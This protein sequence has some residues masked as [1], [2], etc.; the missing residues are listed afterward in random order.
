MDL[1]SK[2]LRT[3]LVSH[4]AAAGIFL[5][6]PAKAQTPFFSPSA[7][8][9]SPSPANPPRVPNADPALEAA[10]R[11]FESL[12]EPDRIAIQDGLIWTGDYKGIADGKFGKGTRDAIAAFASRNKLPTDGT[13]DTKGRASL[14][15]MAQ[16]AKDAVRFMV[17]TDAK[18]GLRIGLPLKLLPK[19]KPLPAGTRLSSADETFSVETTTSASALPDAYAAMIADAAG[20]KVTYKVLRPDFF[21]VTGEIGTNAF[22]TRMA[23]GRRAGA[24]AL[25]GFTV[26]YPIAAKSRFDAITIAI[27][28]SFTPFP[29]AAAV[30]TAPAA[31]QGA[32]AIPR[33]IAPTTDNAGS[34]P[35]LTASGI[36][37][38]PGFVLTSLPKTCAEPSIRAKKAKIAKQSETDGLTLLSLPEAGTEVLPLRASDPASPA[39]IVVLSFAPKGEG[40]EL[41]GASGDLHR[42]EAAAAWR[43]LAPVQT[44]VAGAAVLDRSGALA[45]L[46]PADANPVKLIAGILPQMSRT[47]VPASKLAAFL[48]ETKPKTASSQESHTTGMIV[49]LGRAAMVPIYCGR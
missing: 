10:K 23:R 47:I 12:Q 25:N 28:N 38:A 34:K 26:T 48:A 29:D 19:T 24:E 1:H 42:P 14:A 41:I 33:L 2:L 31:N 16:Q 13:L 44:P 32:A 20:R 39:Q 4:I 46:L 37:V 11:A 40:D 9:A 45:G 36:V 43:L 35:I 17:Q 5:N 27:A 7:S 3:F 30:A 6:A 21:V 22:F 15:A 8:P 18:T 49:A